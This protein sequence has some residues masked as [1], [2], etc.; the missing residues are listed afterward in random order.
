MAVKRL[1][2]SRE[3]AG[4][5]KDAVSAL[6]TRARARLL[7]KRPV[8]EIRIGVSHSPLGVREDMGLPAVFDAAS[9]SEG[10]R[11]NVAM[12][13]A[14]VGVASD[15]LDA[16][17][18]LA[19]VRLVH[20]VQ[21]FLQDAATKDVK[22]DVDTVL[23]GQLAKLMG[24]VTANVKRVV[25]TETTR[26]RNAG[27]FDA[28]TKIAAVTGVE[29]PVVFF[30]GPNDNHTCEECAK[31]FFLDDGVTPKVWL[32]SEVGHGY[33]RKG[34]DNPKVGGCHPHCRHTMVYLAKGYGFEAGRVFFVSLDHDE[35]R[36][37]RG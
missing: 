24:E 26:A 7:G 15:Y 4:R 17:E 35:L 11:P 5:I 36:K 30:A 13:N 12:R 21:A 20:T 9:Q 19:K 29:D 18:A 16:H 3:A 10:F 14:L 2:L 6:F 25:A 33:H 23:G 22:T 37:Q 27:T 1:V 32:L 8:H 28:V 34:E 31:L